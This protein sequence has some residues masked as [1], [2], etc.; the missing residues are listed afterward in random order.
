MISKWINFNAKNEISELVVLKIKLSVLNTQ[1][2]HG[3]RNDKFY[4]KIFCKLYPNKR[5]YLLV[6]YLKQ[7]LKQYKNGKLL[8]RFFYIRTEVEII[9]KP[10]WASLSDSGLFKIDF[11]MLW[12]HL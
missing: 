2:I 10:S 6:P 7:Y 12:K 4:V 5:Y 8:S 9:L 11:R 3:P 1:I